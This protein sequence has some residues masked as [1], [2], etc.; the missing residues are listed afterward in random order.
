MKVKL[1][2]SLLL[3]LT[4]WTSFGQTEG[5]GDNT[6]ECAGF[7]SF[8]DG[9]LDSLMYYATSISPSGLIQFD[10]TKSAE[11]PSIEALYPLLGVEGGSSFTLVK[12]TPSRLNA[13]L[14][15]YKYQQ[16]HHGLKVVGGGHTVSALTNEPGDPC[17]VA[18]MLAPN[19]YSGINVGTNPSILSSQLGVILQPEGAVQ[20]ELAIALNLEG[21]CGYKLVWEA[22]YE[23]NGPKQSWVDAQTGTVLKTIDTY[24]HNIAPTVN[25][26]QQDL[27]DTFEGGVHSLV[28]GDGNVSTAPGSPTSVAAFGTLVIPTNNDP[29]PDAP[30]TAAQAAPG[31]YQCHFVTT[32]VLPALSNA[33]IDFESVQV[34]FDNTFIDNARSF[35]DGD[36]GTTMAFLRFGQ[37]AAGNR[38]VATHDVAGHELCHAYLFDYISYGNI[39]TRTLHEAICDMVGTYG[40]SDVQGFT[41]WGMGDDDAAVQAIDTDRDLENPNFNCWDAVTQALT[42]Q[43]PRGGPL[44]RWFFLMT[45]GDATTGIDGLGLDKAMTIVLEAV[46]YLDNTDDV[47]E[48][49]EATVGA[50]YSHY[51]PCSDE[52]EVVRAAWAEVCITIP[53]VDCNFS[54][55]GPQSVCEED[56]QLTMFI[57]GGAGSTADYV[58]YF[59]YGWTVPGSSGNSYYGPVL[60]VTDLPKYNWY[61]Q[62]FTITVKLLGAGGPDKKKN[63][64][65]TDCLGDDP[66]CEEYNG[67]QGGG[68]NDDRSAASNQAGLNDRTTANEIVNV[69]IFDITG[70]LLFEGS[71]DELSRK[72]ISYPG[73]LVF[74]YFDGFN[75]FVRAEK[76]TITR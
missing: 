58:W 13:D 31:V 22:V 71:V 48:F 10:L 76:M 69:K 24:A 66:T 5:S 11:L 70:R 73:I 61:P 44:R 8:L 19:I 21:N 64:K 29:D 3:A 14:N 1:F 60:N 52:A 42:N 18:Y 7:N 54:I 74:A 35:N 41:D 9:N 27:D 20:S 49:A 6:S 56:D 45:E 36:V 53:N 12:T 26:G 65:L 40:E 59:P 39:G 67:L 15:H 16:Y 17:A 47:D 46:N 62:H 75:N 23:K 72:R 50:T 55:V 33:D 34:A 68:G 51:G 2:L 57:S 37:T 25:Y 63:V 28:S 30:W 38:P 32:S 4:V 43:Y